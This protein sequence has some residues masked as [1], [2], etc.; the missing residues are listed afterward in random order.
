MEVG[1][2][3]W[4]SL[5][6]FSNS[7]QFLIHSKTKEVVPLQALPEGELWSLGFREDGWGYIGSPG[8]SAVVS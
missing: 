6:T 4:V 3:G 5:H 2:Q 8:L 7:Q 1:H